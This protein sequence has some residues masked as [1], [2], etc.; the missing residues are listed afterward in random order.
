MGKSEAPSGDLQVQTDAATGLDAGTA[1]LNG[2]LIALPDGETAQAAFEYRKTSGGVW[3][4]TPEQTLNNPSTFN[5]ALT[6][7][8]EVEH[9]F[10]A[11]AESSGLIEIGNVL[12]F[13]PQSQ[14]VVTGFDDFSSYNSGETPTGYSWMWGNAGVLTVQDD[15]SATGGKILVANFPSGRSAFYKDVLSGVTNETL[16]GDMEIVIRYLIEGTTVS[17]GIKMSG[18]SGSEN[19]YR[20]INSVNSGHKISEYRNGEFSDLSDEV[21]PGYTSGLLQT[22]RFRIVGSV[23]ESFEWD[24]NTAD[25]PRTTRSADQSGSLLPPG[26]LGVLVLPDA[27]VEIDFISWSFDPSNEPAPIL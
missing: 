11:R 2:E 22:N 12:T 27:N 9:E 25:P 19:S 23:L 4:V 21:N 17:C 6:G 10:R 3:V 14:A 16:S 13:T 1:T 15:A 8:D 24:E 20:S 18:S 7:L 5:E 26:R